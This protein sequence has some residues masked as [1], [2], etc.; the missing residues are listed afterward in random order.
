MTSKPVRIRKRSEAAPAPLP[1]PVSSGTPRNDDLKIA[2]DY[3]AIDR[4]KPPARILKK[5]SQRGL[6]AI[7]ASLRAHG[8]IRPI[9]ADTDLK[10]VTG[11]GLLLAAK[12][13]GFDQ[14]PVVQVMH[15]SQEQLQAFAI[16]D[17]RHQSFTCPVR[18]DG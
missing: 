15:L 14:V 17:T 11:Y 7:R 2:I 9:V 6:A 1:Q 10:I 13:L 4:L 8:F 5:H 3:V 18:T 12:E 16:A